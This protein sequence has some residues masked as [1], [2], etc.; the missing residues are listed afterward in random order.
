MVASWLY[1][2]LKEWL[3]NLIEKRRGWGYVFIGL[4][5]MT[6]RLRL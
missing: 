2:S 3:D 6:W 4:G 1:V 5:G